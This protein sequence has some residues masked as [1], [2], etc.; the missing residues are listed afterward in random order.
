MWAATEDGIAV[1]VVRVVIIHVI[2]SLYILHTGGKG[3]N[4]RLTHW[5][6]TPGCGL[7]LTANGWIYG[8][9][10]LIIERLAQVI[11]TNGLLTGRP[12]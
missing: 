2:V 7:I 9:I 4:V 8:T 5:G 11:R 3:Q 1:H 6:R 12:T 10:D